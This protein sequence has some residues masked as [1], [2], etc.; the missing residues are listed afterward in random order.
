MLVF[1]RRSLHLRV[2]VFPRSIVLVCPPG[3][4]GRYIPRK[5]MDIQQT[6]SDLTSLPINDRLRIVQLLWDSIPPE[7]EV[8][9]SP[10]QKRE[11]DR[12][13]AAHDADPSSAISRQ[14]LQRRLKE[15][16]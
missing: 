12:R 9:V 14:E 5:I 7:A 15:R 1:E 11:L 2:L 8:T 10:D 3:D 13:I 6:L 4:L 16:P